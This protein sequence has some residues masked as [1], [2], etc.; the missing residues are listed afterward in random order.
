MT[1]SAVFLSYAH[2]ER[3]SVPP[4]RVVQGDRWRISIPGYC[5]CDRCVC[6]FPETVYCRYRFGEREVAAA[7]AGPYGISFVW[8]YAAF[9][10]S[11]PHSIAYRNGTKP[12]STVTY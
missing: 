2:Q 6:D 3:L 5:P 10:G 9:R 4:E 12:E 7:A 11:M 1:Q 8:Q